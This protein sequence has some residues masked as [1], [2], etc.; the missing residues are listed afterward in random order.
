M[1]EAR[2]GL[3]VVGATL[4]LLF[5]S[6]GCD[7]ED[8][9]PLPPT[10]TVGSGAAGPGPGSGGDGAASTQGGGPGSG[11][12]GGAGGG[13]A[14]GG[15]GG[16]GG[17]GGAQ[18]AQF[19]IWDA[20][21]G[22]PDVEAAEEVAIDSTGAAVVVGSF[23]GTMNLGNAV[24]PMTSFGEQDVFVV[25]MNADGTQAWANHWG[26]SSSD[27]CTAVAIDP[28]NDDIVIVGNFTQDLAFGAYNLVASGTSN[29]IFVAKLDSSGA[30]LWAYRFGD[31]MNEVANQIVNDVA[32]D[33]T[34]QD[35]VITGELQGNMEFG[36]ESGSSAG[37]SDIFV[38][39]LSPEGAPQWIRAY[40]DDAVQLAHAVT[41]DATGQ[42]AMAGEF[43]KETSIGAFALS[44]GP[45]ERDV[46][47]ATL[48]PAGTVLNAKDWGDSADQAAL[49]I[50]T[51][52]T[53]QIIAVG[54]LKGS[55]VFGSDPAH[56][57]LGT[58]DD[59][60]AFT[61][62]STLVEL[63][64]LSWGDNTSQIASG[65][66]VDGSDNVI[67][68][69]SNSGT[70]DFDN[71]NVVVDSNGQNDIFLAKLSS[72]GVFV[73][74]TG[75]GGTSSDVGLAVAVDASDN[76]FLGGSFQ[77]SMDLGLGLLTSGAGS[78]D[79]FVAKFTSG[80]PD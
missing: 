33:P 41:V 20:I 72:N 12:N 27:R 76:I 34:T 50:A 6:H 19:A 23:K 42:I 1:N 66:V 15:A 62:S 75:F 64:S 46:F 40:G 3:G 70:M 52:S 74:A 36:I 30:I 47:I 53:N 54:R 31:P 63:R 58:A 28:V 48:D 56:V 24:N 39:R 37:A 7:G 21:A 22:F 2:L 80:P 35:I 43:A 29:D 49:D 68:T 18:P 55:I 10:S 61:L 26:D 8:K 77:G 59:A 45:N 25:K 32:I 4:L 14:S 57:V 65:V 78:I 13:T 79:A 67:I 73:W 69:G 17:Q 9:R 51:D 44:A 5:V 16:T 11:A 60:F 71:G 38:A